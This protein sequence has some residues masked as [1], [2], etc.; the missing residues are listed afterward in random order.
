MTQNSSK[1]QIRELETILQEDL[2]TH[3]VGENPST[4][5]I[6]F[7]YQIVDVL[8]GAYNNEGIRNWFY[9]E[10][11][12]LERKNPL[13]YLGNDWSSDSEPAKKVLELAKSLNL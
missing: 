10:R 1:E 8:K 13:Q 4:E 9:R 2:F 11:S 7:L 3:L 6:S 5:R 12:E